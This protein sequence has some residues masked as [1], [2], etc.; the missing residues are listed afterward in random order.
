M[1]IIKLPWVDWFVLLIGIILTG[2]LS[3]L[4]LLVINDSDG[5]SRLFY[6]IIGVFLVLLSQLGLLISPWAIKHTKEVFKIADIFAMLPSI[7]LLIFLTVAGG[8]KL[9]R[10]GLD[11]YNME[12]VIF[13]ITLSVILTIYGCQILR[14]LKSINRKIYSNAGN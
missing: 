3:L 7:L 2:I 11:L 13:L 1:K 14:L 8:S 4:A 5:E 10:D 9:L 6:K 12:V